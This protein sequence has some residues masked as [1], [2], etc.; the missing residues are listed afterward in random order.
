[1]PGTGAGEGYALAEYC[2]LE[3][4]PSASS[5]GDESDAEAI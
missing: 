2:R 5:D 4:K 3:R 1:M